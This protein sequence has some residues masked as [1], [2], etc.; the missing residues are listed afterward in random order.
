MVSTKQVLDSIVNRDA[1]Y[2][3]ESLVIHNHLAQL[4]LFGIRRGVEFYPTQDDDAKNRYKFIQ[5][6]W[7]QNQLD[8]ILDRL[9]DLMLCR[10][11]ILFYLRPTETSYRLLFFEK[12][13][14]RAYYDDDG[15]LKEVN[16]IYKY[17]D[18]VESSYMPTERWM[19][20][21]IT[22]NEIS[23]WTS[24]QQISFDSS[25]ANLI[26]PA[27]KTVI[28]SLGFIPCV[29]VNNYVVA[30]GDQGKGEFDALSPQLE[31][32]DAMLRAIREN[33]EFFGSPT[34]ISSRSLAELTESGAIEG[35]PQRPTW[36]SQGGFVGASTYS[37]YKADPNERTRLAGSGLR[38]RRVMANVQRDEMATY[39]TPDPVSGDQNRYAAEYRENLHT[40]L[41]GVDPL[42]I[43]AG[44]T[45]YEIKSLFGR[46]A[47][48]A[49][50]KCLHLYTHGLCKVFEMAI[51]AEETLFLR[52]LAIALK[53]PP[54]E[55]NSDVAIG[56]IAT[57]KLPKNFQA[58]GLTPLGDRTIEW[59]FTG[60]VFE[61]SPDDVL[62]RSLVFRNMQE[63]GIR[64]IEG[65]R[66]MLFPD[67]TDKELMLMLAGGYPFRYIQSL[68]ASA[69]Q[70]LN[71]QTQLLQ[72]P[73]PSNPQAPLGVRMDL[74]GMINQTFQSIYQ[75]MNYGKQF[76][77]NTDSDSFGVQRSSSA[78]PSSVVS[79]QRVSGS[80][81]S[82]LPGS[83]ANGSAN[84]SSNS[85]PGLPPTGPINP[86]SD[87]SQYAV[88]AN[89]PGSNYAAA[90]LYPIST[91]AYYPNGW[92]GTNDQQSAELYG[93]AG[94]S[95]EYQNS[96][97]IPGATVLRSSSTPSPYAAS[98][99]NG[100]PAGGSGS[101]DVATTPGLLQQLFPSFYGAI[102]A[103]RKPN[104]GAGK[105]SKS[106]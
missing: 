35:N 10:G 17:K 76:D 5:K 72:T 33:I 65:F 37:T 67:K 7:I 41:G 38:V 64:S 39:I 8:V 28:N 63:A 21:K 1:P 3:A 24:D 29:V 50:K 97:P 86:A 42:S 43:T 91:P 55:V 15:N 59:R 68:S 104:S 85:G 60:P 88:L 81:S 47:A 31:A 13:Q 71:L 62:K 89:Q 49:A 78:G 56:L 52:S 80:G 83:P 6:L 69:Q 16:I 9:W 30:P 18:I 57:G 61:D 105:R 74:S 77:P 54:E 46:T 93:Q 58:A 36:A 26:G 98:F 2:Q 101:A 11:Q 70:L 87:P 90:G 14:F 48:T 51:K 100:S 20:L 4:K 84:G 53:K 96:L 66:T 82:V 106:K 102:S 22:D 45:A 19:R 23:Q 103:V 94:G 44:A 79:S 34:L 75:E 25:T 95:S 99:P 73:D 12:D 27:V 32:H 40:A 92:P